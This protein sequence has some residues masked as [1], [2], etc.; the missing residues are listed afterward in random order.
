VAA[1]IRK[2]RILGTE[3]AMTD[4]EQAMDAMDDLIARREPGIVCAVAV[5]A[6][7]VGYEDPEMRE[8]GAV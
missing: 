5:H 2:R 8:A 7:T 3:I 6:V 4:Y 1:S